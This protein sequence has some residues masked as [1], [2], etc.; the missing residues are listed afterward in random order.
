MTTTQAARRSA[1]GAKVIA[2]PR[3]AI[4][5]PSLA[6]VSIASLLIEAHDKAGQATS[7]WQRHKWSAQ[8]EGFATSLSIV[9]AGECGEDQ[10]LIRAAVEDALDAGVDDADRLV[11]IA[12]DPHGPDVA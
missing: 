12:R 5:E 8:A 7:T 4:I 6:E 3:R 1:D 10:W 11:R 9:M 2:F